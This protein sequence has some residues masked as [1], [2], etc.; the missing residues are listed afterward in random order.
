MISLAFI[1]PSEPYLWAFSPSSPPW[2]FLLNNVP[3]IYYSI[4]ERAQLALIAIP[5]RVGQTGASFAHSSDIVQI[6]CPN[7]HYPAPH[8]LMP[9]RWPHLAACFWVAHSFDASHDEANHL[10]HHLLAGHTLSKAVALE[11]EPLT[12]RYQV[13]SLALV[14]F[15]SPIHSLAHFYEPGMRE[16]PSRSFFLPHSYSSSV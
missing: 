4:Y 15:R 10:S 7:I 5:P 6:V 12:A 3:R 2:T 11:T 9:S 16:P 1:A 13:I 8:Y 14:S